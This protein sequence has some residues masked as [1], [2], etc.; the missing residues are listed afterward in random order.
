MD[1]SAKW[2]NHVV[3]AQIDRCLAFEDHIVSLRRRE[4]AHALPPAILDFLD[5]ASLH[6]RRRL[7]RLRGD[8][9]FNALSDSEAQ[10]QISR[11]LDFYQWMYLAASLVERVGAGDG[12]VELYMPLRRILT[13]ALGETDILLLPIPSVNYSLLAVGDGLRIVSKTVGLPEAALGVLG[14]QVYAVGFPGLQSGHFLGQCLLGH[15]AGHAMYDPLGLDNVLLPLIQKDE[16]RLEELARSIATGM[17]ADMRIGEVQIRA[18]LATAITTAVERWVMEIACDTIGYAL[19]GPAFVLSALQFLPL[20]GP[21]DDSTDEYPP[22]R[23]R[24]HLLFNLLDDSGLRYPRVRAFLRAWRDVASFDK[25]EWSIPWH[26]LAGESIMSA[27]AE[28]SSATL[29]NVEAKLGV[30]DYRGQV[31]YI[32]QLVERMRQGV[33]PNE[34]VT[35]GTPVT[36]SL[37]CIM[38]AGWFSMFSVLQAT[39]RE[40][41][42][43]E[44][45]A[46]DRMNRLVAKAVELGEVQTRWQEVQ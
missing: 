41:Q 25:I 2:R 18:S 43:T 3:Q 27:S 21:L 39:M 45:E 40:H 4:Y 31:D 38:N 22:N 12:L 15:E 35:G 6:V 28:I 36:A 20:L 37:P 26:E 5:R 29:E 17:P 19:F 42:W 9:D 34:V 30:F 10:T 46:K 44:R 11:Y 7:R 24:L 16:E 1:T 32:D 14:G 33:P 13:R 23:M 8:P